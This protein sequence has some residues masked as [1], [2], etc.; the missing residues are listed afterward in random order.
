MNY[1]LGSPEA[2]RPTLTTAKSLALTAV[3]IMKN[4]AKLLPDMKK[5]SEEDVRTQT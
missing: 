4:S 3:D 1:I 5:Q 2:Q